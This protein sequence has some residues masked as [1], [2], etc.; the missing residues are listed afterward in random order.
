[1]IVVETAVVIASAGSRV[2]RTSGN[3]SGLSYQMTG[4]KINRTVNGL[5]R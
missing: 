3:D 4:I 1:M 5:R 2:M